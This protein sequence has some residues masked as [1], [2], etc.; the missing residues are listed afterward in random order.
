MPI[1][2]FKHPEKDI[3]I[4]D[5]QKMSDPHVYVDEDGVEWERVW[6]SP[7]AGV[8]SQLDGSKESFMKYT[9]NKKG[10]IGDLFDASQ[11][12]SEMRKKERGKDSLKD[13]Y[14]ENYSNRR[15]GKKHQQDP[16][17][18]HSRKFFK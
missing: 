8:D 13:K 2:L 15:A 16:K 14:F 12:C 1:Y 5:L 18:K 11:R 3:V 17:G 6:T 4:E 9:A 10:N 7:N